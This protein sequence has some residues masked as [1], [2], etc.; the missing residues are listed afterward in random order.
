MPYLTSDNVVL[1]KSEEQPDGTYTR[2][3]PQGSL[4]AQ[5][6]GYNS[7]QYGSAGV[8]STMGATLAGN[9]Q[10][11][12]IQDAIRYY[13]GAKV[14]GNDVALDPRLEGAEGRRVGAV[15][16]DGCLCRPRHRHRRRARPGIVT[17]LQRQ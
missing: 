1:A 11:E 3:Y 7:Q 2:V 16:Q 17:H 14:D 6:V 4:A 15:R 10:F 12:S 9:E 8:E 13:S 5:A